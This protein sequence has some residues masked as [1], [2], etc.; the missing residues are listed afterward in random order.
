MN[1]LQTGFN[2]RNS[3][4]QFDWVNFAFPESGNNSRILNIFAGSGGFES[5]ITIETMDQKMTRFKKYFR[6]N[7]YLD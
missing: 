6:L 2:K 3:S 1:C 7:I 5:P 4:T